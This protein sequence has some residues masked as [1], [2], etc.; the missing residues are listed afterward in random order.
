MFGYIK[1]VLYFWWLLL[2]QMGWL[3]VIVSFAKKEGGWQTV[4]VFPICRCLPIISYPFH[5][6]STTCAWSPL[7]ICLLAALYEHVM[8]F[9]KSHCRTFKYTAQRR[10][11]MQTSEH[12]ISYARLSAVWQPRGNCPGN[13]DRAISQC[14]HEMHSG[15]CNWTLLNYIGH[16]I[17]VFFIRRVRRPPL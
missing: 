2:P 3:L 6:A 13:L 1:R 8:I 15:A 7:N 9:S 11:V 12:R 17:T 4:A 10:R 16:V 14:L 5:R